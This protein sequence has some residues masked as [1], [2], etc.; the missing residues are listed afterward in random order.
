MSNLASAVN[1]LRNLPL[2]AGTGNLSTQ[3][4]GQ[5]AQGA[6]LQA[7]PQPGTAPPTA[8]ITNNPVAQ[9]LISAAQ[10][11]QGIVGKGANLAFGQAAPPGELQQTFQAAAGLNPE[12]VYPHLPNNPVLKFLAELGYASAPGQAIVKERY[13]APYTAK[14]QRLQQMQGALGQRT[15]AERATEGLV[16]QGVSAETAPIT[17]MSS[18]AQAQAASQR[19]LN[20]QSRTTM[21]NYTDLVRNDFLPVNVGLQEFLGK[22]DVLKTG[23]AGIYGIQSSSVTGKDAAQLRGYYQTVVTDINAYQDALNKHEGYAILQKLAQ[24]VSHDTQ[25]F[26]GTYGFAYGNPAT[27]AM[28]NLPFGQPGQAQTQTPQSPAG[29]MTVDQFMSKYGTKKK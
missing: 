29:A 24:K 4:P 23:I 15:G 25:G 11:A 16:G 3:D 10:N 19:A 2:T 18:E 22:L 12:S 27:G 28:S 13:Q 20:E 8:D 9:Q 21:A 14:V 7:G 17:A 26:I 5:Q 1:L 6:L